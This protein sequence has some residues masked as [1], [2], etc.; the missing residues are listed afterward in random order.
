MAYKRIS[1]QPVVEGGTGIQTATAFTPVCAG[2]T[3]TGAFQSASTGFSTSGNVLTST[4]ASSLPT[5]Q[6]PSAGGAGTI[7]S[8]TTTSGSSATLT[9]IASGTK[10]VVVSL[11]SVFG[12]TVGELS[13]RLGDSGGIE[14]TG[15]SVGGAA[16]YSTSSITTSFWVNNIILVNNASLLSPGISY[17]VTMALTDASTNAWSISGNGN[18]GSQLYTCN[19]QK[20]LSS[21]LTQIQ[22]SVSAGS[23]NGGYFSATYYG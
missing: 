4:G 22:L 9:G 11:Y 13:L 3:A 7:I 14:N 1:P 19:G 20:A 23:L 8:T 18:K 17:Q 10:L 16:R 15:Y 21:S 2:T 6:T 5:W 12:T